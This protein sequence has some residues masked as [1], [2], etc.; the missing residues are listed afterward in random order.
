MIKMSEEEKIRL[1]KKRYIIDK[2]YDGI[3]YFA[4]AIGVLVLISIISFVTIKGLSL[5][6]FGL[7]SGDY[8]AETYSGY[9]TDVDEYC[10]CEYTVSQ[11]EY[12]SSKWGI[13]L[14]DTTDREG[15]SVVE[16]TYVSEDS[17]LKNMI[18]KDTEQP[19]EISE[20]DL[21]SKIF[22]TDAGVVLRKNGAE[23]IINKFDEANGIKEFTLQSL[24][25]GI[26]GSIITTVYLVLITL[27]VA[28]PLGIMTAI[29]FS[30]FAPKNRVTSILRSLIETLTG[31]PSI[32]YGLMGA[33][34]FIP[35]TQKLGASGGNIIS[36]SLT[37]VVIL[38][39]V[40]IRSTEEAL[41]V[42]PQ[43]YR[44]A[45]LALGA[46][47]TQTTFKVVLPSAIPG[48]LTATLLSIGRIVGESAALIYAIGT[49][50]KDKIILTQNSTSL[51]VH[52]WT[53]MGDEKP[54]FELAS[55]I[56]IVILI[57]VLILNLVV[58]YVSSRLNKSWY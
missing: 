4:S 22:F 46:N 34:V 13:A 11:D 48:I 17:P 2:I 38:L 19:V 24:G 27:L 14:K 16:V 7:L 57:V 10:N 28:L 42:I 12:F 43:D 47:A 23:K 49:A 31:V 53:V 15:H 3:S 39:P 9:I 55:A 35:I 1:R 21:V 6:N 18:N 32:I 52:I 20:G 5:V 51:A 56:A 37:L 44:S 54:N 33:A 36:G 30:E 25:G 45:S 50:I 40:I 26:R 8:F 58:K 29:Y 41:K